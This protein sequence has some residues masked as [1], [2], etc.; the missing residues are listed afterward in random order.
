M[1]TTFTLFGLF[2][3]VS[4]FSQNTETELFQVIGAGEELIGAHVYFFDGEQLLYTDVTGLDGRVRIHPKSSWV[5]I[6]YLGYEDW[7]GALEEIRPFGQVELVQGITLAT[8]E[9][10]VVAT[11]VEEDRIICHY[12]YGEQ[13]YEVQKIVPLEEEVEE[14]EAGAE[15]PSLNLKVYPNPS[16]SVVYIEGEHL[17][18]IVEL[19]ALD[20]RVV[21]QI[22]VRHGQAQF[23]LSSRGA[24]MYLLVQNGKMLGKVLR[25]AR[26]GGSPTLSIPPG[27]W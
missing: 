27:N 17:E 3:S 9:V 10:L 12:P 11:R 22:Y 2:L 26:Y 4:L 24:G 1:K 23:D 25:S 18:G 6:T 7:E 8:A 16:H 19:Y 14:A 5:R 13:G 15:D 21:E 20:G